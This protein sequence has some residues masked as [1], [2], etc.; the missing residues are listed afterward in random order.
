M[1]EGLSKA[2]IAA[3][4]ARK[5][6]QNDTGKQLHGLRPERAK[7]KVYQ[8]VAGAIRASRGPGMEAT[9]PV[10][11][12]KRASDLDSRQF[13]AHSATA[14]AYTY[15]HVHGPATVNRNWMG[16]YLHRPEFLFAGVAV[17]VLAV[18][19]QVCGQFGCIPS[20]SITR[21]PKA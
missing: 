1:A 4:N 17:F 11:A 8:R 14:S 19:A 6:K 5:N 12:S 16:F 21:I 13:S 2:Q 10:A 15:S 18:G 9:N 7:L 20:G 3:A